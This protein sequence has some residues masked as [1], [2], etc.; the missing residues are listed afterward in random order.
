VA[1][2]RTDRIGRHWRAA[3]TFAAVTGLSVAGLGVVGAGPALAV[4][5]ATGGDTYAY[6]SNSDGTVT[7]VDLTT[8]SVVG[9]PITI[10]ADQFEA[11]PLAVAPDGSRLYVGDESGDT[12]SVIDTG[13]DQLVGQP[14][15]VDIRP[16]AIAISPDGSRVYVANGDGNG[17]NTGTVSVIDTA[18]DQVVD[19]IGLTHDGSG[20]VDPDDL[21]VSPDGRYLYVSDARLSGQDDDA[22]VTIIDTS[23]D[24]VV[25]QFL[26][27]PAQVTLDIGFA[28]AAGTLAVSPDG[29]TLYQ[30]VEGGDSSAS[31]LFSMSTA[32]AQASGGTPPVTIL[33]EPDSQSGPANLAVAPNGTSAFV[34]NYG[35]DSISPVSLPSGVIGTSFPGTVPDVGGPWGEAVSS[36]SA[37]L[38]VADS[39][40]RVLEGPEQPQV[41]PQ[42]EPISGE[43]QGFSSATGAPTVAIADSD[44]PTNI[45]IVPDQAPTASFTW[46]SS[47]SGLTAA[48]VGGPTSFDASASTSPSGTIASYTWNFGDGTPVVTTTSPTITHTYGAAGTY[49]VTLTVTNSN[50]TSTTQT[51]TGHTVSNQGGPSAQTT[52][53]V[54]ESTV[55]G[56]PTVTGI[57]P[58]SGAPA[59]GN[60]ITIVGTNLCGAAVTFGGAAGT[61]VIVNASCTSLTVVVPAGSGTVPVVVTTA[62]GSATSPV[63]YTYIEPGYW[64]TAADGGVFSFGGA[65]F[66]GSMAGQPLDQ[67][68]VGMAETPDHQGYWL[69]AADG[70]VFAFGDAPY[71][72]SV[73]GILGAEHRSLNG[74]IVAVEATPDGK[75][76]RMFAADGGVFDFGDATFEGSLPSL[77]VVPNRPMVAAVSAPIGQGYLLVG[78]DGGVF[79]FG[80]ATFQGSLGAQAASGIVSMSETP[81]GEGYWVFAKDGSVSTFG[82][83]TGF[84]SMA[85]QP[86]ATPIVFGAST[87][88]SAGYWL[89][90]RD[91]GVFNFGDAPFLGSLAGTALTAPIVGGVGF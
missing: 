36:N 68:I 8:A 29:S 69:F 25:N 86:L 91:G 50:G 59:G 79:S 39:Q 60:T 70:G 87:T 41:K 54:T 71:L 73:P 90:S 22:A 42:I 56:S 57:T 44:G 46:T 4:G 6:V 62:D 24:T 15:P 45:A 75:G 9:S 63:S 43:I 48:S 17:D 12:V 74:A 89:F 88:T 47:P 7:E 72:G 76:Y 1:R 32:A 28:S 30:A 27:G 65:Q 66:Y 58:P 37:T 35:G 13:A 5:A 33:T 40:Q 11:G 20:V 82:D 67:P 19:D 10:S 23:N 31:E 52:Q 51:Y 49:A 3:A 80:D 38:W 83:A 16:D 2:G 81:S 53:Q 85:G 18:T 34:T 21:V 84:G 55:G 14:I 26:T 77:G 78:A 61:D 64:E